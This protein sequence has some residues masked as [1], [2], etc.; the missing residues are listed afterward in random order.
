[1]L[2]GFGQLVGIF[3][4]YP[5]SKFKSLG[6]FRFDEGTISFESRFVTTD[7]FKQVSSW[8]EKQGWEFFVFEIGARPTAI[9]HQDVF[10]VTLY[11]DISLI[12][13]DDRP[14]IE[15]SIITAIILPEQKLFNLS[16]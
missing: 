12:Y 7:K 9:D 5:S 14:F 2:I 3:S 13:Y 16:K 8:Y 4:S 15:I 11:R 6:S 10:G 1:M